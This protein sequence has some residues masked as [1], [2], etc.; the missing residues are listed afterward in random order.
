MLEDDVRVA[1]Q[2]ILVTNRSTKNNKVERSK[3][4]NNQFRQGGWKQD[5]RQQQPLRVTPMTVSYE[6][7]IPLIRE[8]FEFK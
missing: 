2:Q 3:P 6:R 5:E 1:S 4:L 7:F 8:L